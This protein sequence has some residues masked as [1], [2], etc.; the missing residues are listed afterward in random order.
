M[1]LV[2]GAHVPKRQRQVGCP[3]RAAAPQPVA[4]SCTFS[5]RAVTGLIVGALGTSSVRLPSCLR[6]SPTISACSHTPARTRESFSGSGVSEGEEGVALASPRGRG[7]FSWSPSCPCPFPMLSAPA[8]LQVQH[9]VAGA[10]VCSALTS[11][12]PHRPCA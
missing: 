7:C 9:S 1:R 4:S 5:D 12:R 3:S 11:A 2:L 10:R 8:G 6:I